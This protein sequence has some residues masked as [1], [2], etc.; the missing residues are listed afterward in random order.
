MSLLLD[1]LARAGRTEFD[2]GADGGA[3]PILAGLLVGLTAIEVQRS[4]WLRRHA[5]CSAQALE[6]AQ[7]D[8]PTWTAITVACRTIQAGIDALSI[9]RRQPT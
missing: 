5:H 1:A 7:R 3:D 2:D 6:R 9:L 4:D 8:D